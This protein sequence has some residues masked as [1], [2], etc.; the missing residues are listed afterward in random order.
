MEPRA[1]EQTGRN[2]EEAIQAALKALGRSREEVE[3]EVLAEESRGLLGILGTTLARVR[4]TPRPRVGDRA[5]ALLNEILQAAKLEAEARITSEDPEAA[6]LEITGGA[7]LGLLIG[8]RGQTLS[9]LQHLVGLIANKRQL[10]RK[11]IVLD[12]AGYRARRE[13]ALRALAANAATRAKRTGQEV[14]LEPLSPRERR[15]I[16]LA[17]A[18]DPAVTTSSVGEDPQRQIVISPHRER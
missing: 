5:V 4:V 9:A 1:I 15:I 12:A 7:D 8:R 2:V 14:V 17:L 16:H 11:K 6:Y 13:R 18:D 10:H 3:I